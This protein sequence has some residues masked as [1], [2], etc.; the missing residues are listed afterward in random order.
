MA[1]NWS[2]PA[3]LEEFQ[4]DSLAS[5][6]A[7]ELTIVRVQSQDEASYYGQSDRDVVLR[8]HFP[9]CS[10]PASID[11]CVTRDHNK[12]P[13]CL[14]QWVRADETRLNVTDK[15][16]E[17]DQC[18]TSANDLFPGLHTQLVLSQP[19]SASVTLGNTVQLSCTMGRET[20]IET[21]R[22]SW[23]QKK[24][25]IPPRFLLRFTSDSDKVQGSGVPSRF[26]GSKD[27]SSNAGYLTI[28]KTVAED[29]ADYFC[30]VHP[31][32]HSDTGR[33]GSKTKT[34]AGVP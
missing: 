5:T 1:M 17:R 27:T 22:V 11:I 18:N 16:T 4:N 13:L 29:E 7:T 19:P 21:Y 23:Y 14:G 6:L 20:S 28:A 3:D 8:F 32:Y 12:T 15:V 34:S 24:P 30:A 10:V 31:S 26:S 9:A 25:G 2:R 33:W